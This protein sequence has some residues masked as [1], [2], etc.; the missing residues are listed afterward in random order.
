[1]GRR[2]LTDAAPLPRR[3]GSRVTP[4]LRVSSC[5]RGRRLAQRFRSGGAGVELGGL[6]GASRSKPLGTAAAPACTISLTH[7]R[8]RGADDRGRR[9]RDASYGVARDSHPVSTTAVRGPACTISLTHSRARGADDRGRRR[10]DASYGVARDSHPVSTTAVRGRLW[11]ALSPTFPAG[12]LVFFIPLRV[13]ADNPAR[14]STT[15]WGGLGGAAAADDV[16]DFFLV[17]F[18]VRGDDGARAIGATDDAAAVELPG[19]RRRQP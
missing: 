10:R 9:R 3:G 15:C 7:S 14:R 13:V 6:F 5:A 8:A 12:E 17:I 16:A 11:R 2:N 1:M 19:R 18:R 4:W